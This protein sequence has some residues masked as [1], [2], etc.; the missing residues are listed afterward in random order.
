MASVFARGNET[1]DGG[2]RQRAV[3]NTNA[4][5]G[6][7]RKRKLRLLGAGLLTFSLTGALA[8]AT[9]G[10]NDLAN[11]TIARVKSVLELINQRSPGHRTEA[12]LTKI[13]HRRLATRIHE[14][15]LP[16][17]RTEL[18]FPP[19]DYSP[20]LV[21]ILATPPPSVQFALGEVPVPPITQTF[22][23]GGPPSGPPTFIVPQV[24][25]PPIVP[26]VTP[27]VPEPST[28]MTML[29]GFALV[30]WRIRRTAARTLL[31]R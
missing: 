25:T 20:A 11:A 8:V 17:I 15:A 9:F 16:K 3:R 2:Q 18:P 4:R 14:R 27:A 23:P 19:I 1:M 31:A 6:S 7:F 24:N 21:D 28:W 30:G 10:G 22:P 5:A 29:V 13:K 26:P 12:H